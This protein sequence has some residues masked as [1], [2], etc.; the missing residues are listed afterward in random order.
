MSG[1]LNL[2]CPHCDVVSRLSEEQADIGVRCD[3]CGA[4][5][6]PGRSVALDN[7]VRFQ[8][9]IVCNDVPVLAAF[10]APWCGPCRVTV[11]E[12]EKAAQRLE[13]ACRLVKVNTDIVSVLGQRYAVQA[14]PT[15]ILF[16]RGREV[17]RWSGSIQAAGITR[18]AMENLEAEVD[19]VFA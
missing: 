9:H 3:H 19:P 6:F 16:R 18:F 1:F 5:M 4:E 15:L 14:I 11:P 10:W 7:P 13:P 8:K 2:V 17:A 12:F